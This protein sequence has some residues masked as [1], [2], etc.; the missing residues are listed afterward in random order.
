MYLQKL[1]TNN[2]ICEE[3]KILINN[4]DFKESLTYIIS[5]N[6]KLSTQFKKESIGEFLFKFLMSYEND[7]NNPYIK[8]IIT[9]LIEQEPNQMYIDYEAKS[10]LKNHEYSLLSLCYKYNLSEIAVEFIQNYNPENISLDSLY[11]TYF[12]KNKLTDFNSIISTIEFYKDEYK[13][14]HYYN[15]LIMFPNDLINIDNFYKNKLNLNEDLSYNSSLF[16]I[17]NLFNKNQNNFE[18]VLDFFFKKFNNELKQQLFYN[19]EPIIIILM[20]N[21][22]Y[23]VFDKIHVLK[24]LPILKNNFDFDLDIYFNSNSYRQIPTLL[25]LIKEEDMNDNIINIS[26]KY[27]S[28]SFSFFLF[29]QPLGDNVINSFTP[30]KEEDFILLKEYSNNNPEDFKKSFNMFN[31]GLKE[32]KLD[33]TNSTNKLF[34]QILSFFSIINHVNNKKTTQI[35][36]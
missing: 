2:N 32:L 22:I 27:F 20:S 4:L 8:K 9:H 35:K 10:K 1:T 23:N 5:N 21:L 12:Y 26:K 33:K 14:K 3:F 29:N 36:I 28:N 34:K 7:Y 16:F 24:V 19:S 11:D 31:L 25:Q 18:N 17:T 15:S 30:I 6:I 13:N